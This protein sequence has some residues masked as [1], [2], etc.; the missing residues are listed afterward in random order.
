VIT[1]KSG[2]ANVVGM[3]PWAYREQHPEETAYFD[4]AMTAMTRLMSPAVVAAYDWGQFDVIA[5][6]AGGQGAQLAAIL[7][8][9]PKARG[10]LFDQPHVV[11]GAPDVLRSAGVIDRVE[12]VGG[13]FFERVPQADAYILKHILH[14]W[15]DEDCRRILTTIRAAAPP[16]ARLLVIERLIEGPNAG[17]AAKLSDLNMLVGPGGMERTLEEFESLL[18]SGGWKLVAAHPAG[19]QHVIEAASS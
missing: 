4:R 13:T 6:I 19:T 9:N 14:D 12:V 18:E 7:A 8:S 3:G 5:D 1:G 16:H 2:V 15:N 11:V 17:S 10:V